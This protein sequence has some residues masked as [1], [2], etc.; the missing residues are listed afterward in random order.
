MA[1]RSFAP[2]GPMESAMPGQLYSGITVT[3]EDFE[4]ETRSIVQ[5]DLPYVKFCKDMKKR[6]PGFA[7]NAVFDE[8]HKDAIEFLDWRMNAGDLMAAVKGT[9]VMM[10]LPAIFLLIL[11]YFFE[12]GIQLGPF[13]SLKILP[14]PNLTGTLD[15]GAEQAFQI[16]MVLVLLAG[17]V[18]GGIA[19]YIFNYP[20]TQAENERNLA[21]TYVP[22]MV[23]YMI[24]SMKLVPN[25]EKAIEFSSKHGRGKVAI[26]F[27]KLI[28]DFELG[29]FSSISEGLDILAYRWG[30]YSSELKEA[31]MRI[32]ASVMEPS[33]SRRYQVLD[34][35]MLE[36][37]DSVK[38]K[39]EDYAR[40]L[41]QP[42]TMLFYLGVLLPLLLVIILPVGSAFSGQSLA[43]PGL[44]FGIFCV[45]IPF[46]AYTFASGIVRK[47]PPT[48]EPPIIPDNFMGLPKKW[49]IKLG[50][51]PRSIDARMIAAGIVVI[52]LILSIVFSIQGFPPKAL[53]PADEDGVPLFSL[54]PPDKDVYDLSKESSP[55]KSPY[56]YGKKTIDLYIM[57]T[58][59][60]TAGEYYIQLVNEGVDK[61]KAESAAFL[62]Y[63]R[64][65]SGGNDSTKYIFWAGFFFSIVLAGC[66][67]MYY[68]TI[69]KR[70]AQLQI[71]QMEDEF[72][73][74]MYLI[75]SRMGENKPVE[76]A[77]KHARDFAPNM[78]ISKRIFGKT[79]ENI[80]LM[81]LPL[82]GA[83][84]DPVYGAMKGIPSK[85]L[86]TAM[87]LLVDSV[88][89]GVEVA[90]RTLMS[91][92]L[93]M[94]NMDKVNKS[95]K[96]MVSDVTTTMQTMAIFIAPIVLGITV[97]L[98]KVVMNTLAVVVSDPTAAE[99]QGDAT[100]A[101]GGGDLA[102]LVGSAGNINDFFAITPDTF[103]DFATPLVFLIVIGIY[104]VEIVM[105]LMF[106]TVKVQEDND[107]LFRIRLAQSL[108][109]AVAI[110]LVTVL[111]SNVF[112]ANLL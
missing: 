63:L 88:S 101:A 8:A 111:I 77:L 90:S 53:M 16:F 94:E 103:K 73:E 68:R 99:S 7:R 60:I 82:E 47:R 104:V 95:L 44:L 112:I 48:Y 55:T 9:V 51:G 26:D 52:G 64:F 66:I 59:D 79:V 24:M 22:E 78:I 86:T 91:L 105:I 72:K 1:S 49:H 106:F 37:L 76:S 84:F 41:N 71:M 81:G 15:G 32:R 28:W 10:A 40:G 29:V 42:S 36:V 25:L 97:A 34:K 85:I 93:Q 27:K 108:P 62:E 17:G 33:T 100:G 65:T 61:D 70:Q 110:F 58:V 13:D 102:N 23:G 75:A 67:L 107:L 46:M 31:L 98:Q 109:I 4:G 96:D 87:R 54:L 20:I 2:N 43:Q 89:L 12:I 50:A 30:K 35:T 74:S 21:L 5:P 11:F 56:Y 57:D 19:Y 69:Y 14:I 38:M 83:V 45:G 18:I 80:E 3:S 92:S 39:M 6:F